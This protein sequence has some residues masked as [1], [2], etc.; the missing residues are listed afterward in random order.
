MM[1]ND[2]FLPTDTYRKLFLY[3]ELCNDEISGLGL[4]REEEGRYFCDEVILV[5][6]T[7]SSAH[8]DIT[9]DGLSETL[10]RIG[11]ERPD[12]WGKWKLWWHSHSK[13][14]ASFSTQDEETLQE[15]ARVSGDWFFG[16]VINKAGSSQFYLSTE[17][18]IPLFGKL[19]GVKEWRGD[20]EDS[21]V[22]EVMADIE[23]HVSTAVT[24]GKNS[25]F[26]TRESSVTPVLSETE[27]GKT[28][29]GQNGGVTDPAS[30]VIVYEGVRMDSA[31]LGL[32]LMCGAPTTY[33]QATANQLFLACA[34]CQRSITSC[35]CHVPKVKGDPR[36]TILQMYW[37]EQRGIEEISAKAKQLLGA[38]AIP[39]GG[40]KRRRPRNSR[41]LDSSSS[42]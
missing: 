41:Q 14:G 10:T 39:V 5:E 34:P 35:K 9:P 42:K 17:Q 4:I 37:E 16:L 18:P 23:R 40:R 24:R 1:K 2:L 19:E 31:T 8:T 29:S 20:T 11:K 32:C 15:L 26:P 6:Q 7:V 3:A 21:M 30:G 25:P 33:L 38:S 22:G 36:F 27:T 12:T 13:M 28:P